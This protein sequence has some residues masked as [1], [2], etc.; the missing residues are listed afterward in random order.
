MKK[1][2]R[3]MTMTRDHLDQVVDLEEVCFSV[4]WTR[5]AFHKELTENKLA[6][7]LVLEIDGQIVG[8]GGTWY[9]MDEGHITNIAI[10]PQYRKQG[11]GR[12]LVK[13]MVEQALDHGLGHMTLEVRVS[14]Q[15]AIGLYEK[16]HFKS[17]GVR[18]KYY[19]DNQEDALIMW[20][21]LS[22]EERGNYGNH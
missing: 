9:I 13:A 17:E 11:L 8:Y 7:Y 19:T 16:M 12:L 22:K 1:A 18:P 21:D 15:A 6:H 5:E 3:I 14:N 20:L 4:P 2:V 10:D